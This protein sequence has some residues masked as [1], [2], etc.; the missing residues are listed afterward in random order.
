MIRSTREGSPDA[1]VAQLGGITIQKLK[2][3]VKPCFGGMLPAMRQVDKDSAGLHKTVN[4][5]I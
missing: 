4:H 3:E 5:Q 1:A 2:F